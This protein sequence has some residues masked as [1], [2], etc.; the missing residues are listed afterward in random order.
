MVKLFSTP[1]ADF[2]HPI[3]LLDSCHGRIRQNCE[4]IERI[5]AHIDTKGADQEARDAAHAVVRFF[6]TAGAA[7]HR[8]EEED[9]FPALLASVT[10]EELAGARALIDELRADHENLDR[11]WHDMR[12]ALLLLAAVGNDG[13][14]VGYAREFRALYEHHIAREES[15]MLPL[16]RRVLDPAIA[17]HL[18]VRMAARRG[19]KRRAAL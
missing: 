9:L 10:R 6:D 16:A 17:K 14:T 13:L 7:H 4:R 12:R 8:D 11:A 19:V 3:D 15:A 2:D 5:A 1:S 18:G